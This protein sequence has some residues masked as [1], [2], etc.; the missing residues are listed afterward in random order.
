MW[1]QVTNI[2]NAPTWAFHSPFS[3]IRTFFFL[4]RCDPTR[5]MASSFLRFLDHTQLRLTVGRT[6]LDEWSARRRDL[7]VTTHNTHNRQ[8]S[9]PPVGFEPTISAGERPQTYALDRAAT[10]TGWLYQILP[11]FSHYGTLPNKTDRGLFTS[12]LPNYKINLWRP[13]SW[14]ELL[15]KPVKDDVIYNLRNSEKRIVSGTFAVRVKF[16]NI[17][18]WTHILKTLPHLSNTFN[19]SRHRDIASRGT[20]NRS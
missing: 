16:V 3:F 5:V 7:Y 17:F 4:W 10:G 2:Q 9:M 20:Y 6:P 18:H 8:T 12:Y 15:T 11:F 1:L 13:Y 19:Y 14:N